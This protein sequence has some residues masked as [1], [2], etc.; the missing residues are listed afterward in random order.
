MIRYFILCCQN[1]TRYLGRTA[2]TAV[3][4]VRL[5]GE[6]GLLSDLHG[7]HTE[8]PAFDDL[9][10]S[11]VEAELVSS[12]AT[13][14]KLAAV[15]ETA[16]VVDED[17]VPCPGSVRALPLHQDLLENSSVF[18]DGDVLGGGARRVVGG[19]SHAGA[20]RSCERLEMETSDV[21]W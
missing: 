15:S 8:V 20:D 11:E 4:V 7:G 16:D 9:G 6:H 14:V 1:V 13:G 18:L 19:D 21:S 5:D 17:L 10:L 12:I 3:A 2:R